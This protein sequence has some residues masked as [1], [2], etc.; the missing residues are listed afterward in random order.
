MRRCM[1]LQIGGDHVIG[2]VARRG[3]KVA[4]RPEVASPVFLSDML[5][6][7]LDTAGGAPLG[8]LYELADRN[9]R[10]YLDEQMHMIARQRATD[11]VHAHLGANLP[12][13]VADPD[14]YITDQN[15]VPIFRRPND[16]ESVV[17]EGVTAAA[18]RHSWYP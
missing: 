3:G 18:I 2:D 16:M 8:P 7:L 9:M 17:K 15:L 1:A 11:D 14:A 12:D 4:P 5:E 10:W 13:N 6:L